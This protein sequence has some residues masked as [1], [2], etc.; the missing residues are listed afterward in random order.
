MDLP[1][2]GDNLLSVNRKG[3]AGKIGHTAAGFFEDDEAGGGI[4][5]MEIHF[6]EPVAAA[7]SARIACVGYRSR[8]P[9]MMS[10]SLSLSATVTRFARPLNSICL[11]RPM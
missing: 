11:S 4:P 8:M 1:V 9:R 2:R 3:P 7:S 5:G 10:A 6:P